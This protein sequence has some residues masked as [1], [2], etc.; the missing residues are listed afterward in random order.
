M[1]QVAPYLQNMYEKLQEEQE[2]LSDDHFVAGYCKTDCE[3]ILDSFGNL[4]VYVIEE[5][6]HKILYFN[7]RFRE[8]CPD[9]RLGMNCREL[10]RGPCENCPIAKMGEHTKIHCIVYS[11]TFGDT[12]EITATRLM[13]HSSIPAIM[14]SVWPRNICGFTDGE[15]SHTY[16]N[17]PIDYLTGGLTRTGFIRSI[18]RL[19]TDGVNLT[20]YAVLF[21]NIKDFKAVNE[22]MGSDG[23]DNL[24]RTIYRRMIAS[25]LRPAFGSRKESDHFVFLVNQH[26]IDYERL[27][28]LLSF[29]WEYGEKELFIHC[30]CGIFII[31]DNYMEAYKMI[32]RAKLA[33]D[34]I[35]DEYIKPYAVYDCTMLKEYSENASEFL[36]FDKCMKN[37]EFVVYYQPVMDAKSERIIGAEALVRRVTVDGEVI[38]PGKFVPILERTGYISKLDCFVAHEV[39]AF[40]HRLN[41]S[42]LPLVPISFNLSQKDFYDAELMK[43]LVS[44][45]EKTKLPKG[46]IFV[47]LTESAYTM[48]EKKHEDYL[49]HMRD[50]G[51]EIMLDDFGTGYSSFGMF[52]N[53]NF[54]R[55]K[56]D[57]SFVHQLTTNPNVCKVVASIIAMCHDLGI[58]VVAEGVETEE[59]LT[60][61]RERGCDY[62]QGYYFSKPLCESD[63]I[64]YLKK[65]A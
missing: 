64:A 20:D 60:L 38:S 30:R 42:E 6:T 21:I 36:L 44:R 55:I 62:I 14:V 32:D 33:K 51:A 31:D 45:F 61:L 18:E 50:L 46:S 1:G 23:G 34:H 25:E 13:W 48:N 15:H 58:S 12:V 16:G 56:L 59:E 41:E 17:Y 5:A 24:L 26:V 11:D 49:T 65:Y 27:S 53:Y 57:M 28:E 35:V 9:V 40:L 22:M 3:N 19:Q 39:E 10:M 37:N 29:S 54:D 47:E 8:V 43:L 2:V 7:R 63:F 52:E 4:G